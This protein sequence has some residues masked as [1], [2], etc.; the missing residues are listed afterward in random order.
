MSVQAYLPRRAFDALD[1]PLIV[2]LAKLAGIDSPRIESST[3]KIPSNQ[4]AGSVR[5]TCSL[6]MALALLEAF[7]QQALRSE[8][9]DGELVIA[10]AHAVGALLAAIDDTRRATPAPG[11]GTNS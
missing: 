3:F 5:I 2:K 10:T 7:R 9:K 8:G 4:A 11:F 1:L 6:E